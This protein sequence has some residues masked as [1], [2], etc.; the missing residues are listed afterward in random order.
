MAFGID[1]A[2]TGTGVLALLVKAGFVLGTLRADNTLWTTVGRGPKVSPLTG[3]KALS[4]RHLLGGKSTTEVIGTGIHLIFADDIFGNQT[5]FI[6]CVSSISLLTGAGGYMVDD[7]TVGVKS[8]GVQ[9]GVY[10]LVL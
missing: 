5:T 4:P 6:K 8:A 2:P 7:R 10:T 3:A 1:P 9:A